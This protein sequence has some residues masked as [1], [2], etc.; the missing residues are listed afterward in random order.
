MVHLRQT[1]NLVDILSYSLN[2][3]V[4]I[5]RFLAD[6]QTISI[7]TLRMIGAIA[8][9]LLWFQMFFWLRLFDNTAQYVSLVR[10]TISGIISFMIV[11]IMIMFAFGTAIYLLQLNRI[12]SG[13]GEKN[14]I[15]NY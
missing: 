12:Y 11:M 9:L 3:T 4:M 14:L 2:I 13:D 1:Q 15:F 8:G 7:Q 6:S 5:C 10:L